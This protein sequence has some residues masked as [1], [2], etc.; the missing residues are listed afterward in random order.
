M[1]SDSICLNK[2]IQRA[3]ACTEISSTIP[4]LVL[5]CTGNHSNLTDPL[6]ATSRFASSNTMPG[7]FPSSSRDYLEISRKKTIS[8]DDF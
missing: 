2:Q 1:S 5:V 4:Q 7:A 3:L 8:Q 6:T